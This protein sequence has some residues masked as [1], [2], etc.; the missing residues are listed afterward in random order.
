MAWS[1]HYIEMS[2]GLA[3]E[4]LSQSEVIRPASSP[5]HE[6]LTN[7]GERS[8][9]WG[10]NARSLIFIGMNR[11]ADPEGVFPKR[12]KRTNSP[13]WLIEPLEDDPR[14]VC[15]KF[16][17][18]DAA[19]LEGRLYLALVDREE[20]WSGLMV[21]TSREHHAS[22]QADFSQL[23]PHAVLGKWLYLSQCHPDFESVAPELVMLAKKRD[24]RMGVEAEKRKRP[25]RK[26]TK[27]RLS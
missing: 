3:G 20:P 27:K 12:R 26:T 13:L 5:A 24:R 1:G 17:F 9:A 15:Q 4:H 14:F 22:L 21:C 25:A 2:I 16:F 8:N 19:Y 7:P 6:L 18:F 11:Q 10:A 23:I